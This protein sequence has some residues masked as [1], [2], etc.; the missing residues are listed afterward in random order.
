MNRN[1]S[2]KKI[3][4]GDFSSVYSTLDNC[5]FT[6]SWPWFSFFHKLR[7]GPRP[8][9]QESKSNFDDIVFEM[10]SSERGFKIEDIGVGLKSTHF[11]NLW[12]FRTI[13]VSATISLYFWGDHK[14]ME[15]LWKEFLLLSSDSPENIGVPSSS[16]RKYH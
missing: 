13:F 3:D 8:L 6:K 9:H 7:K 14:M 11:C 4:I 12:L 5:I 15:I 2:S 10:Y 1:S 16:I